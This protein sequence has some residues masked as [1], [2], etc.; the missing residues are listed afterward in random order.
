M[1]STDDSD[2]DHDNFNLISTTSSA[3]ND[4]DN[5]KSAGSR[6]LCQATLPLLWITSPTAA[7][8][9]DDYRRELQASHEH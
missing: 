2:G 8:A 4:D 3:D 6:R 1:A 9:A 5:E 7:K